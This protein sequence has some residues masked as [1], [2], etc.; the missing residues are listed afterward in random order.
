ML[1]VYPDGRAFNLDESIQRL[2]YRE[3]YTGAP[4]WMEKGKVYKVTLP[5]LVTRNYSKPAVARNSVHHS[6]QY[7]SNVKFSMQGKR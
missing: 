2:R 3:G 1:D 6:R 5:P 4:V 7:P